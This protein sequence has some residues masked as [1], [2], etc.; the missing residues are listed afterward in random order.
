MYGK[1]AKYVT[2]VHNVFRTTR[3]PLTY[4]QEMTVKC[5][6]QP[7]GPWRGEEG[8]WRGS[9]DQQKS[10]VEG[11]MELFTGSLSLYLEKSI[12]EGSIK[13]NRMIRHI[14][15]KAT[16]ILSI[17]II[18]AYRLAFLSSQPSFL[19]IHTIPLLEI[20]ALGEARGFLF[21]CM[22]DTHTP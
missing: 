20:F 17:I 13:G 2:I 18:S 14:F 12:S 21:V 10:R 8:W 4:A 1:I 9:K 16:K 3:V 11:R 5:P 15:V 7:R 19:S 22:Y 6:R